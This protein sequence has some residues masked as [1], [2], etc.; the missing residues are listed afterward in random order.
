MYNLFLF[1][2][3]GTIAN[4]LSLWEQAWNVA[5]T[6][7]GVDLSYKQATVEVFGNFDSHPI[8]KQI[9]SQDFLGLMYT[10][11]EQYQDTVKLYE[12]V[13]DTLAQLKTQH[14]KIVIVTSSKK[15]AVLPI[16]NKYQINNYFDA[17]YSR[18]DV[19]KPKPDPEIIRK[20]LTDFETDE[21]STVV[22]GD[23]AGDI[24][25]GKSA[26]ISTAIFFPKINSVAHDEAQLRQ[27]NSDY[28]FSNFAQILTL[29]D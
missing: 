12:H 27:L 3:D 6:H 15:D 2:W 20:A 9:R 16:I 5:A 1:D 10:Y 11:V 7:F 24:L 29:I 14:K 22:I 8:F 13:P 26:G 21:V 25:A 4:T 23:S 18:E 19:V 17:I 28:F